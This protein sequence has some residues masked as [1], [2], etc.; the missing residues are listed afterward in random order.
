MKRPGKQLPEEPIVILALVQSATTFLRNSL[1]DTFDLPVCRRVSGGVWNQY[2][3][4]SPVALGNMTDE[5]GVAYSHAHPDALNLRIL[6][7]TL[8]RVILNVRDPRQVVV[9][10]V[11]FIDNHVAGNPL[12]FRAHGLPEGY[13]ARSFEWKLAY[14][15]EHTY[16]MLVG[17]IRG[18]I[19]IVDSGSGNT[20]FL[21]VQ[22]SEMKADRSAFFRKIYRFYGVPDFNEVDIPSEHDGKNHNFFRAGRNDEW[23]EVLSGQQIQRVNDSLPTSLMERFQWHH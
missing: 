13:L 17:W 23:R 10:L 14:H 20:R 19:D 16:P 6:N 3:V 11:H 22:H 2:E 18:W 8:R 21:V 15:L 4:L 12:Y 1:A 7:A 9:S 5:G